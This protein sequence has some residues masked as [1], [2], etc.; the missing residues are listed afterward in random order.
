MSLA[1]ALTYGTLLHLCRRDPS[2]A[3][4]LADEN[5][6]LTSEHGFRYWNSLGSTYRGIAVS[7]LGRKEEGIADEEMSERIADAVNR[8]AAERAA[9]FGPEIMRYVE[10]MILLQTV[11]QFLN[12]QPRRPAANRRLSQER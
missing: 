12:G 10:K 3:L 5:R 8:R 1:F 2:R 11:Q 6:K 4:E 9:N 7:A